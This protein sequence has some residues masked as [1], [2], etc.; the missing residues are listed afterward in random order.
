MTMARI[1]AAEGLLSKVGKP[2]T[3]QA[4]PQTAA[5]PMYW[6]INHKGQNHPGEH[7]AIITQAQR[8][9][10]HAPIETDVPQRG[11]R[12]AR[13]NP[14]VR[15][16]VDRR[17]RETVPSYT[18]KRASGTATTS[19]VVLH[20]RMGVGQFTAHFP[21]NPSRR[22]SP[23]SLVCWHCKPHITQM[24]GIGCVSSGLIDEPGGALMRNP[25]AMW[26][27][28]SIPPSSGGWPNF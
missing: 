26:L 17:R 24:V 28:R 8:D 18:N 23:C 6:E 27:L 4:L 7:Q 15:P 21:P 13:P 10:V 9:A 1:Y 2:L 22:W 19:P 20:R 3:K 14:A 5:Q 12:A 25:A 11:W 16:A